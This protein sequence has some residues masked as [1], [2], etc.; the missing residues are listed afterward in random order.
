MNPIKKLAPVGHWLLRIAVLAIVYELY[1]K[2]A[3][4]FSFNGFYYFASLAYIGLTLLLLMGAFLKDQRLTVVSGMIIS[5]LSFILIF[6]SGISIHSLM[7][8]FPLA[9]LGFYFMTHGNKG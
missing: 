2:E 4:S 5:I 8:N 3:I 7:S 9:A 1:F 6:Y